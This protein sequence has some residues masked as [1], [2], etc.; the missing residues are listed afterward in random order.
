MRANGQLFSWP[1][2]RPSVE[3]SGLAPGIKG[4][5]TLALLFSDSSTVPASALTLRFREHAFVASRLKDHQPAAQLASVSATAPRDW[6][7]PPSSHLADARPRPS[8]ERLIDSSSATRQRL[9]APETFMSSDDH[10]QAAATRTPLGPEES[11]GQESDT[12]RLAQIAQ[13]SEEV[14]NIIRLF[15]CRVCSFPLRHPIILPCGKSIC[16]QCR[17]ETHTRSNISYPGRPDRRQGFRCPFVE[18]GKEHALGDC[19]VDVVLNKALQHITDEVQRGKDMAS[20]SNISTRIETQDSWAVAGITSMRDDE[21]HSKIVKGGKIVAT[22]S[23]AEEGSL[24]YDSEVSYSDVSTSPDG[25]PVMFDDVGVLLKAQEQTRTE[26]DCQVCYGL[27][28]DP[29]TTS[30]GHTY[31]RSCLHRILD[32]AHHCPICRAPLAMNPL[33]NRTSCPSNATL[34]KLIETFW[35]DEMVERNASVA[36]EQTSQLAEFDFPL[37]VCT[38]AFPTMPTFLH[39]FEPRYR[40]MIRRAMES[41]RTFGMVFPKRTR[42]EDGSNFHELGTLLRIV[43]VQYYADGRSLIETVGLSRFR[44]LRHG[45][46]DGYTV[47]KIERIDDVSL[48]EEEAIE[49]TETASAPAR[50]RDD[51]TSSEVPYHEDRI[52][53]TPSDLEVMSTQNLMHFATSFVTRMRSQSA[54]WLAERMLTIYGACP[55]DAAKF[56]WWF[57]SMLPVTE[58]EKYRLLGT[59]SISIVLPLLPFTSAD[60]SSSGVVT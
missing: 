55:D 44:V 47:G 46:L 5:N 54:P 29:L 60:M 24:E 25:E 16:M 33:L 58:D 57:A 22:F 2:R 9:C 56:P 30:C 32:H 19:G 43:N 12:R 20:K 35:M 38:L 13:K 10:P 37:F 8:N 42:G 48:E 34:S 39:I 4:P 36:A 14:R 26:M 28:S 50:L 52:L 53:A 59:K 41:N 23:L 6:P 18:C 17:P 51:G 15:Q 21:S 1:L 27:F 3:I 40:L 31:C 7:N 49:V 11:R 45:E